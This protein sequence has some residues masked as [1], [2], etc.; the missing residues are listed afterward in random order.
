MAVAEILI[1]ETV[2]VYFDQ[3]MMEFGLTVKKNRQAEIDDLYV[4]EW[5]EDLIFCRDTIHY[6]LDNGMR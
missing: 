6:E 3:N 1:T 2:L 5:L 4:G